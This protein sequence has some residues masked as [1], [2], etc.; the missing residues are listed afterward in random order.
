VAGR[1][2]VRSLKIEAPKERGGVV[3]HLIPNFR[4]PLFSLFVSFVGASSSSSSSSSCLL[5]KF[6]I[7]FKHLAT[8]FNY[9]TYLLVFLFFSQIICILVLVSV[10]KLIG[11]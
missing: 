8:D 9:F 11:R 4:K 7:V 2:Q 1:W 6:L 10:A 5:L 3:G